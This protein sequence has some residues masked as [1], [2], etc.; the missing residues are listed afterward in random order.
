[1]TIRPV[2]TPVRIAL[3][4]INR[5]LEQAAANLEAMTG[6]ADG[7]ADPG[8]CRLPLRETLGALRMLEVEGAAALAEECLLL[9]DA[10]DSSASLSREKALDALLYSLLLLPRYLDRV[11]RQKRELPDILL[12][13]LNA[14]RGLRRAP[15][16]PDYHFTRFGIVPDELVGDPV[17]ERQLPSADEL[18]GL[19][20]RLRHMFQMGLLGLFR[21][22][23]SAVHAKQVHRAL[24]R[25]G[26]ELGDTPGGRWLRLAATVMGLVVQRRL[27]ADQSLR[28]LLSRTDR[29]LRGLNRE[30]AAGLERPPPPE[31]TEG[32]LYFTV[33]GAEHDESLRRLKDALSLGRM[34]TPPS[35][36]EHEREALAAPSREV[37][38]A[39]SSA[40]LED[41]DRL[42]E[43]IET[44]A[45]LSSVTESERQEIC[46]HLSRLGS[47][48]T[49]VGVTEAA[50]FLKRAHTRLQSVAADTAPD[51]VMELLGEVVDAVASAEQSVRGLNDAPAGG[52]R[53]NRKPRPLRMAE[54]QAL[55]EAVAGMERVRHALEYLNGDLDDGED[56]AT[57]A[58]SM[59]ETVGTLH[60][61]GYENVATLMERGR[62]QILALPE[63][64]A[65][66]S[67]RLS[68]LADALA[69]LEWYLEGMLEDVDFGEEALDLASEVLAELEGHEPAATPPATEES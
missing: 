56:P 27:P 8:D 16:L 57:V 21:D 24:G 2:M 1:M 34:L 67:A 53:E 4:E 29:Y 49:L 39:V 12:P 40:L 42:Q 58:G 43:T 64:D 25:L 69:A 38:E 36:V 35:L 37:M 7:D 32:L 10:Q 68:S 22:P 47:T 11:A 23:A 62:R 48:L 5:S 26:V 13:T 3:A 46:E 66:G 54:H 44:L 20:R 51:R 30:G 41:M 9:L 17:P 52:T 15:P 31:V 63:Y 45:R 14:L 55:V 65:P 50:A 28:T 61:I 19:L 18:Q 59:A 33:I 60:L 6:E